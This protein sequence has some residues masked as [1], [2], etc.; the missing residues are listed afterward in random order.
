MAK[1]KKRK[2][3]AFKQQRAAARTEVTPVEDVPTSLPEVSTAVP[4]VPVVELKTDREGHSHIRKDLK[5]IAFVMV[6]NSALM[7]A[8]YYLFSTTNLEQSLLRLIKF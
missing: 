8:F 5:R 1:K 6:V 4:K 2:S 7:A 3:K